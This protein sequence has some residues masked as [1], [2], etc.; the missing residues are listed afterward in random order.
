MVA[1]LIRG[2]ADEGMLIMHGGCMCFW[3]CFSSVPPLLLGIH[4]AAR[5]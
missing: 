4:G 1:A 5:Q 3:N 2:A